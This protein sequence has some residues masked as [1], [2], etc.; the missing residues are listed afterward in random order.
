M[1]PSEAVSLY[2]RMAIQRRPVPVAVVRASLA[3][4]VGQGAVPQP[5]A[6]VQQ[7]KPGCA[8]GTH[9]GPPQCRAWP[10]CAKVVT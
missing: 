10:W 7:G 6:M 1:V 5:A 3:Q 2:G 9:S 8:H 4:V